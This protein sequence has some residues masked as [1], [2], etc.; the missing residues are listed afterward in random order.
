MPPLPPPPAPTHPPQV[1]RL[2]DIALAKRLELSKL[3]KENQRLKYDQSIL[4][5][6]LLI[7]RWG[8]P[9]QAGRGIV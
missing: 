7:R 6:L 4:K 9:T 2:E 3:V 8:Q 1:K 5:R